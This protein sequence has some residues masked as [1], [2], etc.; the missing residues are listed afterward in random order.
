MLAGGGVIG[1]AEIVIRDPAKGKAHAVKPYIL[2]V[3]NDNP[4]TDANVVVL[5]KGTIGSS[6]VGISVKL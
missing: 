4:K 2:E 1:D 3:K 6:A 5:A